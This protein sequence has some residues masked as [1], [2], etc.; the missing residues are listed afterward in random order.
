MLSAITATS[1]ATLISG[2]NILSINPINPPDYI[3][4]DNWVFEN[5]ILADELFAK[6]L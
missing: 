5:F 6:P 3:I 1:N 4:L 2:P